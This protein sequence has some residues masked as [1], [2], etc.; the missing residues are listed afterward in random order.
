MLFPS[1]LERLADHVEE[2]ERGSLEFVTDRFEYVLENECLVFGV[3]HLSEDVASHVVF[4]EQSDP[5]LN[6]FKSEL[7]PEFLVNLHHN[8]KNSQDYR[9][10][11]IVRPEYVFR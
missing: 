8:V 5:V 10:V 11:D 6:D 2:S 9:S 7:L 4:L 1:D 3:L